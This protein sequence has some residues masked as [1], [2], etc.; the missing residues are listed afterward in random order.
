MLESLDC[1]DPSV[2]APQAH[3][4]D[5]AGPV[6]VDAQRRLHGEVPPSGSPTGVR[7]EAGDDVRRQI[8][9]AWRLAF[10]RL[11][12][13]REREIARSFVEQHGL[14]QLCLVLFNAN[15]FLFVD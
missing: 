8:D 4:H 13:D 12:N 7:R 15:E 1:P 10:A 3:E 14:D 5:H 9:R 2:M 11:P 6:A